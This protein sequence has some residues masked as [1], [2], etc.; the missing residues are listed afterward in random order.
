MPFVCSDVTGVLE[1]LDTSN[2]H[3]WRIW[4]LKSE[5]PKGLFWFYFVLLLYIIQC[6][7]ISVGL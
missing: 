7:F 1:L 3:R 6:R 4:I 2:H 5:N